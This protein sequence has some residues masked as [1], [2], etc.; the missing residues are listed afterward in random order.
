MSAFMSTGFRNWYK[1]WFANYFTTK[2]DSL[3]PLWTID[4]L[5][6][7]MKEHSPP[8]LTMAEKE[9]INNFHRIYYGTEDADPEA[10]TYR[11]SW[12]GYE[13]FKC[14]LDLWI[15][16]EIIT[17]RKPDVIVETGTYRGGSA[18][19]LATICDLL[20]HGQVVTIDIDT[21]WQAEQPR[22]P[23]ITYL[24]GSSV[25]PSVLA[26]VETL[27]NGQRTLVILDSDHRRDHVLAELRAFRSFIASGD[28]LIVEDTNVNGH[29]A[30]ASFG[31][32]PW[33][34][35]DAFLQEDS[36]FYPDHSCTRFLMTMN[37]TGFLR[38][39]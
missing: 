2:N 13:M 25:D 12:L 21:T 9:V 14:P 6:P 35:V 7:N 15:Y 5:G 32:G 33:E 11:I 8:V 17:R 1:T 39:R 36:S 4:N 24:S 20:G 31:P 3:M 23:R 37:P 16:Q 28:Y 30:Y 18:L 19:Y 22:H 29:P 27:I 38:R 34:A 26:H 10:R